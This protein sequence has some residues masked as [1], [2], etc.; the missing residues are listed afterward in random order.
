MSQV[1]TKNGGRDDAG[2]A[3]LGWGGAVS[4]PVSILCHPLMLKLAGGES[5]GTPQLFP[6]IMDP[7][8]RG[9]CAYILFNPG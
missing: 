8:I 9:I 7:V 1:L 2:L 4:Q 5:G 3:E 6:R